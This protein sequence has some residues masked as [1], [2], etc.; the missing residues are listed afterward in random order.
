MESLTN[1]LKAAIAGEDATRIRNLIEQLQQ[2]SYA[3]SQQLYQ[4]Q[5]QAESG[6]PQ[7]DRQDDDVVEGDFE[8]V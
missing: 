5:G 3:L 2:A 6:G 8:E 7:T 1:E 4:A